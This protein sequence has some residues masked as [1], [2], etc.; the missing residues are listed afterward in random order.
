MKNSDTKRKLPAGVVHQ[1][2]LEGPE[3]HL[4]GKPLLRLL[5]GMWYDDG[6]LE[7]R[8]ENL[9]SATHTEHGALVLQTGLEE[10]SLCRGLLCPQQI[11]PGGGLLKLELRQSA[12]VGLEV[13][14]HDLG[15]SIDILLSHFT[16]HGSVDLLEEVEVEFVL[17]HGV[18]RDLVIRQRLLKLIYF[19]QKIFPYFGHGFY[20]EFL[21][22]VLHVLSGSRLLEA[23]LLQKLNLVVEDLKLLE[24]NIFPHGSLHDGHNE[25]L[26][27]HEVV[28][29]LTELPPDSLPVLQPEVHLDTL[30]LQTEDLAGDAA[31]V[32]LEGEEHGLHPL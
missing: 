1:R 28:H 22:D 32:S 24:E 11:V 21:E 30:L 3:E 12:G 7:F 19:Q 14:E 16:G 10:E 20:L 9:V 25:Q 23:L 4:V 8:A 15:Q 6:R 18:L 13:G 26:R 31:Q 29:K 5:A 27:H 2:V 17:Q